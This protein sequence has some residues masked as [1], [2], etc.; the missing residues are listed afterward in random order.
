MSGLRAMK[1]S[2]EFGD[3]SLWR[4]MTCAVCTACFQDMRAAR[5]GVQRCQFGGPFSGYVRVS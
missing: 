2:D 1:P 5:Q 4:P 3:R